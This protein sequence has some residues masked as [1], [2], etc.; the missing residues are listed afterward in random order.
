MRSLMTHDNAADL[1]VSVDWLVEHLDDPT[2]VIIDVRPADQYGQG[3]IPEARNLELYPLQIL[4]SDPAAISAWV[5]TVESAFQ[6]V[7]ISHDSRVVFYEDISGTTAARGVWLMQA[8]SI[9]SGAM[10]DGGLFAWQAAGHQTDSAPVSA[11]QS[12][13]T[14][15][16]NDDV[17]ATATDVTRQIDASDPQHTI[18]DTRNDIEWAQGTIPTARHLD[19]VNHLAPDGRLRPVDELRTLYED[20]GLM[21]DTHA[22][23]FCG[24]GFRAAHT[25]L[26]LCLLGYKNVKNYAPSWGEWGRREDLPVAPAQEPF[27]TT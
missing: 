21:P 24:S 5:R 10:L 27:G 17:F 15:K 26:V 22:I 6:Q 13:V 9:G 11:H 18:V 4:D 3:H 16:L 25:W 23:T 19:W 12:S 20:F 7:G 14:A 1:L 2:L 8:L